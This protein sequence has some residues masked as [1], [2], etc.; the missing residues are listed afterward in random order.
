MGT[1]TVPEWWKECYDDLRQQT[2]FGSVPEE[3]TRGDIDAVERFLD[4]HPPATVLDLFCG[5]GR[6]CL[7]LARRGYDATGLDYSHEYLAIAQERAKELGVAPRFLQ[8]D[9]RSMVFG[10]GYDAIIVMWASFGFFSDEEDRL[11]VQKMVQALAKT[12]KVYMEVKHRDWE[13]RHVEPS[14]QFRIGEIQVDAITVFDLLRSRLET[15]FTYRQ[16]RQEWTRFQSWRV[17]SAH[18]FKAL[19]EREGLRVVGIYG[20]SRGGALTLESHLMRVVAEK[21]EGA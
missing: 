21:L 16:G 20:D 17:Y 11:I 14:R 3:R 9:A 1:P 15:T 18:E 5:T 12:G 19:L 2:G 4:L 8:G 10:A 6:H 7:E 13:V